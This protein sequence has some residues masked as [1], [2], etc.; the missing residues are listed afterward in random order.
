[1]FSRSR[2][3]ISVSREF[4][5]SPLATLLLYSRASGSLLFF[6]VFFEYV[7]KF[8]CDIYN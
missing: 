3:G 7:L 4:R 6:P 2:I 8:R 5:V 1:M